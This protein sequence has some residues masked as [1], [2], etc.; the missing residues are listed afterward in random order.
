GIAPDVLA[1]LPDVQRLAAD[2]VLLR[3]HTAGRPTDERVTAAALLS[4]VHV[5]SAQAPVL[6][7]IDDV[8][9]LDPSSR[10]VLAFVARRIKGAVSV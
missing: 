8:Q 1:G 10:A 6:I 9:W 3:E 2:R 5:M 7:A 4:A